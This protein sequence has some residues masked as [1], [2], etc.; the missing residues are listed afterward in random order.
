MSR[1]LKC[2]VLRFCGRGN[3]CVQHIERYINTQ[4]S[5][6]QDSKVLALSIHNKLLLK[7]PLRR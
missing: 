5:S 4:G 1:V 7:V 2:D 3:A 6:F